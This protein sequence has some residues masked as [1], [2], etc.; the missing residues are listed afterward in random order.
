[1][2]LDERGRVFHM[3]VLTHGG[4]ARSSTTKRRDRRKRRQREAPKG[5]QEAAPRLGAPPLGVV[6]AHGKDRS[7]A[8][9]IHA[10]SCSGQKRQRDQ[11]SFHSGSSSS[12]TNSWSENA[13]PPFVPP[14]VVLSYDHALLDRVIAEN[15]LDEEVIG[16][17]IE[18]K[19]T[20]ARGAPPSPVGLIQVSSAQL[21]VLIPVCHLSAVPQSL[22][23]LLRSERTWKVGCGVRDDAKKLLE[24]LGLTCESLFEIGTAAERLQAR[25]SLRFPG[26]A[27]T[28][29]RPGL[30]SLIEACGGVISKPK[31]V[32]RS[33]WERRPL[34]PEQQK[35]AAED[36]YAGIWLAQSI[37]HLVTMCASQE[38]PNLPTWVAEQAAW[39]ETERRAKAARKATLV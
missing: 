27:D 31:K 34:L 9:M 13:P 21:C 25:G 30:K 32:S 5:L 24:D 2:P 39:L 22:V 28:A 33:N 11:C 16:L 20:F 15:L 7:S 18:W 4:A 10:N 12:S 35:Y 19:P 1:M 6:C 3:E 37:H 14:R 17:D 23:E 29:V 8:P 26:L 38:Q 36:A